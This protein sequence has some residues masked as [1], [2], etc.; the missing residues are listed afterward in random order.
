MKTK[1]FIY[2]AFAGII[3]ASC[4]SNDFAGDQNLLENS[5][6]G[7]A[8]SFGFDV[9]TPTRASG[10]DAATALD[11]QF[12]VWGE[13]NETDGTEASSGNK[14][15]INYQ[16]NWV[17]LAHSTTSNTNGWEYVGY[18]HS[19]TASTDDYQGNITPHLSVAQEIKYW[20]MSASNYVFTAVSALKNDIKTGKVKISKTLSGTDAYKKGYTITVGADA[21]FD[22]LYFADRNIVTSGYGTNPVTMNFR[23]LLSQIRV[24]I[25]E[26][27]PGYDV[28]AIKFYQSDGTTEFTTGTP[29]Q[30][31]FG[32]TVDNLKPGANTLT[33]TYNNDNNKPI[34]STSGARATTITLGQNFN[35][36]S[37]Y[38]VMKKTS[39]VPTWETAV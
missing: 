29:A 1:N 26:T 8:I 6:G 30:S 22:H 5:G 24:G 27:V 18:T 38:A 17:N 13:K 7:G 12:I 23:N 4:S 25:Y 11:N 28:S 33:V 14:V 34:V 9:P 21:D 19:N 32:A 16:V 10:A 35:T 2:A 3:L 31:I 39:A 36:L 15:F 37:T 20:D